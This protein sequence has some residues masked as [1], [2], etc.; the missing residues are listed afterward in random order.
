AAR[1]DGLVAFKTRRAEALLDLL[2]GKQRLGF[3]IGEK[4]VG[5]IEAARDVAAVPAK[6]P[7]A[8]ASSTCSRLS[9]RFLMSC[10]LLRTRLRSSR[11]VKVAGCGCGTAAVT[12]RFS[13]SHF[14]K[15]PSSS[16]TLLWPKILSIHQ[17]RGAELNPAMS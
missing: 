13:A 2:H 3:G 1:D 5:Q 15:P 11:A 10:A 6:R 8:R 12:G 4:V 17:T 14:G 16:E 9:K 7:E